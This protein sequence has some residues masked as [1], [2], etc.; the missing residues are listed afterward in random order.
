METIKDKAKCDEFLNK[1]KERKEKKSEI[2]L[3]STGLKIRSDIKNA[4]QSKNR[5]YVIKY[6]GEPDERVKN[7]PDYEHFIYKRPVSRKTETDEPDLE[8]RVIFRRE[9]V[10]EVHHISPEEEKKPV[11]ILGDPTRQ[12][13]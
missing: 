11:T 1:T 13:K 7:G 2:I 9:H 6:L 12:K 3:D 4:L 10:S 5:L 8:I